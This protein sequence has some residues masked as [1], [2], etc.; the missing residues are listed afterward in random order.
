MSPP[1]DRDPHRILQVH[2]EARIEVIEAAFTV[3]REI[4]LREDAHDAPRQLAELNWAHR[5][6]TVVRRP[7]AAG[8]RT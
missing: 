1:P 7:P 5:E 6:L 8:A 2:H 3:L 4:V